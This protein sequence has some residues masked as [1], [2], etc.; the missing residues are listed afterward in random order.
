MPWKTILFGRPLRSD[1]WQHEQVNEWAGLALL[2]P[3]AISSVA[4]GTE[5]ILLVLAP[6]GV[7]AL[8]YSVPLDLLKTIRR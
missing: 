7:A 3:N 8:W 2:A 6:L 5:E 1:E 4:Y